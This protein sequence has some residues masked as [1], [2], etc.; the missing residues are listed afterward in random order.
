MFRSA[1]AVRR[2]QRA[3]DGRAL[4]TSGTVVD[5]QHSQIRTPGRGSLRTVTAFHPVVEFTDRSGQLVRAATAT[6]SKPAPARIGE[7]RA[8]LVDPDDPQRIEL[9]DHAMR[10]A[11]PVLHLVLGIAF[12]LFAVVVALLGWFL[13]VVLDVPV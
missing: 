10:A 7:V 12:A 13:L 5:L 9:A 3:F 8:I 11:L 4:A 2:G 6:G 1:L